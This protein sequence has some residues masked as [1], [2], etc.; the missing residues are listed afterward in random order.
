MKTNA[1]PPLESLVGKY[2]NRH[3]WS[4]AYP[5][6]KIVGTKGKTTM[7]LKP[8]EAV[9]VT[10]AGALKFHVGGF[11]A[12][13]SNGH[14]QEWEYNETDETFELRLS[15]GLMKNCRVSDAPFRYHDY[16]F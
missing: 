3:G 15:K 16:N 11:S 4:D 2:L 13:C 10:P 1:L 12:Y 6:G 8:I 7:I 9:D 14:A 5:V